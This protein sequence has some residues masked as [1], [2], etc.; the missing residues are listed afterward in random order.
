MGRNAGKETG[1]E[2]F[3]PCRTWI[4]CA[5]ELFG[6]RQKAAELRWVSKFCC[7]FCMEKLWWGKKGW[8]GSEREEPGIDYSFCWAVPSQSEADRVRL[9]LLGVGS[10]LRLL[11]RDS[12]NSSVRTQTWKIPGWARISSQALFSQRTFKTLHCKPDLGIFLKAIRCS[13]SQMSIWES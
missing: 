11:L 3:L 9:W 1:R 2:E 6:S 10:F 13:L 8:A 12:R 4:S 5:L 7:I